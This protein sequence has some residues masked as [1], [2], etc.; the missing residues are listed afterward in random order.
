MDTKKTIH[1]VYFICNITRRLS[2]LTVGEINNLNQSNIPSLVI[3]PSMQSN[4]KKSEMKLVPNAYFCD[5]LLA[6]E[7][8]KSRD[9]TEVT[10]TASVQGRSF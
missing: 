3:V 10:V 4:A 1:D 8:C 7:A 2:S 6:R 9:I 5:T